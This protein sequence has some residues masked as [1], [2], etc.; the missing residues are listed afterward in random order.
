[1]LTYSRRYDTICLV[2]IA[3]DLFYSRVARVKNAKRFYSRCTVVLRA[4][5]KKIYPVAGRPRFSALEITRRGA[6]AR[7]WKSFHLNVQHFHEKLE[8]AVGVSPELP[9]QKPALQIVV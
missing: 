7:C 2:D 3:G 9:E 1:V 5:A 8:G 6:S 4:T